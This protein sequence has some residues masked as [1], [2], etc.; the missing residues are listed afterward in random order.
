MIKMLKV[1]S[2]CCGCHQLIGVGENRVRYGSR[3]LVVR[4]AALQLPYWWYQPKGQ[5]DTSCQVG[6]PSPRN[7]D[8]IRVVKESL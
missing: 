6:A 7:D 2:I 5:K 4:L 1:E 8:L 3:R